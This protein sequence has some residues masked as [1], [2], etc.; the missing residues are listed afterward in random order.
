MY[1]TVIDLNDIESYLTFI[2][3]PRN[4]VYIEH[5]NSPHTRSSIRAFVKEKNMG[6]HSIFLGV[7]EKNTAA[8]KLYKNLGFC[9]EGRQKQHFC[10][11]RKRYDVILMAKFNP[12]IM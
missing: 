12:S 2:N 10:K 6:D 1:L 7:N 8:L 9:E 3:D 5:A 4:D 11:N